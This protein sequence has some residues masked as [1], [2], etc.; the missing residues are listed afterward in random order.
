M[1]PTPTTWVWSITTESAAAAALLR[2]GR[3]AP[4]P[5]VAGRHR[6]AREPAVGGGRRRFGVALAGPGP[7]HAPSAPAPTRTALGALERTPGADRPRRAT[8]RERQHIEIVASPRARRPRTGAGARMRAPPRVPRRR[9]RRPL[10]GPPRADARVSSAGD[11][12]AVGDEAG[13]DRRRPA[14]DRTVRGVVGR[15]AE[16]GP[17]RCLDPGALGDAA[18][19][20]ITIPAP[21]S[22]AATPSNTRGVVHRP[23]RRR[24]RRPALPPRGPSPAVRCPAPPWPGCVDAAPMAACG[25]PRSVARKPRQA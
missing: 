21:R 25:S 6:A 15:V 8:R 12:V 2:R 18:T 24:G 9:P 19:A 17:G 20:A 13:D 23:R 22:S 3:S 1:P 7:E 5:L 10:G 11:R 14:G 16:D 4:A